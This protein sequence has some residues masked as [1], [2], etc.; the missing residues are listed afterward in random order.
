MVL[1][2]V[3]MIIITFNTANWLIVLYMP[4]PKNSLCICIL[5]LNK[6]T[7]ASVTAFWQVSSFT[8]HICFCPPKKQQQKKK[9]NPNKPWK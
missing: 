4:M 2:T 7:A 5:T 8:D 6:T 1:I 9:K 3:F